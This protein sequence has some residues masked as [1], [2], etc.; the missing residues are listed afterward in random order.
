MAGLDELL[1]EGPFQTVVLGADAVARLVRVHGRR[2]EN[3]G[4]VQSTGLPVPDGL[5]DVDQLGMADDLFEGPEAEIKSFNSKQMV[6][7][8]GVILCWAAASEVWVR[9]QASGL[10]NWSALG[11]SQQFRYRAVVAAPPP[12]TRKS[13]VLFSSKDIDLFV[14]LSDKAVPPPELLDMLVPTASPPPAP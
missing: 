11:R 6:D 2:F 9:A 8:D 3:R 7:C 4:E 12:G 1:V 5:S 13:K 14:D 10:R